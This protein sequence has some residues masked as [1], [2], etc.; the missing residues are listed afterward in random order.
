M[1]QSVSAY[2]CYSARRK[3][4]LVH[5]RS[6]HMERE[7][8]RGREGEREAGAVGEAGTES[9]SLR[10]WRVLTEEGCSS[11]RGRAEGKTERNA[12]Q[13]WIPRSPCLTRGGLGFPH[14]LWYHHS[15]TIYSTCPITCQSAEAL[16][17]CYCIADSC[18]V[19]RQDVLVLKVFV[20]L[21]CRWCRGPCGGLVVS[22]T[23]SIARG[24]KASGTD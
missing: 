11:S 19:W 24:G 23:N 17:I 12:R 7:R 9:G 4:A 1:F 6:P 18:L 20:Q 22:V 8:E 10:A 14:C 13:P 5:V 3:S 15:L 16:C 2:L 21:R